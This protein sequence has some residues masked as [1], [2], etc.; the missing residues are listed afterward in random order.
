MLLI[1]QRW[2][3]GQ[4]GHRISDS[5]HFFPSQI[6]TKTVSGVRKRKKSVFFFFQTYCSL[7]QE[8]IFE[9]G[10]KCSKLCFSVKKVLILYVW[11]EKTTRNTVPPA[12][13]VTSLPLRNSCPLRIVTV[14]RGQM[15]NLDPL[16]LFRGLKV[17]YLKQSFIWILKQSLR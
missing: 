8:N 15:L 10:Q 17:T 5:V 11:H 16:L 7:F 4:W 12:L 13:P 14:H 2:H 6:S 9:L 3:G 1:V